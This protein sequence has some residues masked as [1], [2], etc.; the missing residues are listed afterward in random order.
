MNIGFKKHLFIYY[1]WFWTCRIQEWNLLE[2]SS[3]L[4][5]SSNL[6]RNFFSLSNHVFSPLLW[7]PAKTEIS[8]RL[9]QEK[10]LSLLFKHHNSSLWE[11]Y[12]L[13]RVQM[14]QYILSLRKLS[15][16]AV[17]AGK[18][19]AKIDTL[20]CQENSLTE[21]YIGKFWQ[22]FSTLFTS[23]ALSLFIW[24]SALF[25]GHGL[26]EVNLLS[27]PI[28]LLLSWCLSLSKFFQHW[29]ISVRSVFL[30]YKHL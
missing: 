8:F 13:E 23:K 19:S 24:C 9:Q 3:I 18:I 16:T 7:I 29:S 21:V 4:P 15:S 20:F 27:K 2:C 26:E 17:Y 25:I 28:K 10:K 11:Q 5:V 6:L 1:S 14:S 12:M 30:S 22:I